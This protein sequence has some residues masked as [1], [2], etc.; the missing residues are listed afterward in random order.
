[1]L[2]CAHAEKNIEEKSV[3]CDS[4]GWLRSKPNGH[5]PGASTR[6]RCAVSVDN[7]HLLQF[8]LSICQGLLIY[9][10]FLFIQVTSVISLQRY[11]RDET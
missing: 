10:Y 9:I 4:K 1:M 5:E 8:H 7:M 6:S 3:S 2:I 11:Y